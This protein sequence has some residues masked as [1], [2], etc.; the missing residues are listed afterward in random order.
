MKDIVPNNADNKFTAFSVFRYFSPIIWANY[1]RSEQLNIRVR[2]YISAIFSKEIIDAKYIYLR[3]S[4]RLSMRKNHFY[5]RAHV[6]VYEV[7]KVTVLSRRGR[8]LKAQEEQSASQWRRSISDVNSLV[9]DRR[10]ISKQSFFIRSRSKNFSFRKKFR[11]IT[12]QPIF[13]RVVVCLTILGS[14]LAFLR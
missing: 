4:Q 12:K 7:I 2:V 11:A 13:R 9:C 10:T 1:V 3:S 14:Y 8:E 6:C 5:I